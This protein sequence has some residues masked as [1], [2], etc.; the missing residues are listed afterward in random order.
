MDEA[1]GQRG[2]GL[3]AGKPSAAAGGAGDEPAAGTAAGRR[4]SGGT[5]VPPG[6]PRRLATIEDLLVRAV[7][8]GL[9]ALVVVQSFV[10]GRGQLAYDTYGRVLEDWGYLPAA[11]TLD[12]TGS[13]IPGPFLPAWEAVLTLENRGPAEAVLIYN[14]AELARLAPGR[15]RAVA[16]RPADR[17]AVRAAGTA[18]AAEVVLTHATGPIDGPQPGTRWHAGRRETGIEVDWR[19]P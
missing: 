12:P 5:T 17:L 7:V 16:V 13:T 6:W 18:G 14:G 19:R 8:A 10:T 4:P 11:G 1:G 9:V 2:F 15:A 3:R